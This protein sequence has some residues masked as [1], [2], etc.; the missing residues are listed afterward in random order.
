MHGSVGDLRAQLLQIVE[1]LPAAVVLQNKTDALSVAA[2][3]AEA[4]RSSGDTSVAE[5]VGFIHQAVDQ[6]EGVGE[7]LACAG[8]LVSAYANGI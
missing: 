3:L 4:W 7:R 6:L 2:E 8:D 5:V 1:Q